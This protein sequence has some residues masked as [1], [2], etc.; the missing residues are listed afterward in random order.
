MENILDS[1]SVWRDEGAENAQLENMPILD[2]MTSFPVLP[3][4]EFLW[5]YALLAS[6]LPRRLWANMTSS[7]KSEVHDLLYPVYTTQPVVIYTIQSV[8]KS[9][10]KPVWQTVV[11]CIQTFNLLSNQLVSCKR[12]LHCWQRKTTRNVYRKFREVWTYRF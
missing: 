11:S 10:V 7:T 4:G 3:S 9:V 8:V 1:W 2:I 5:V 6:S 12:A